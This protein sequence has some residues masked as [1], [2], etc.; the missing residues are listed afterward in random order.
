MLLQWRPKIVITSG[1]RE[2]DNINWMIT[3]SNE[4]T[5][6]LCE[7]IGT[8]SVWSYKPNENISRYDVIPLSGFYRVY[9]NDNVDCYYQAQGR[10]LDNVDDFK[11]TIVHV[12]DIHAHIDEMTESGTRC[13]VNSLLLLLLLL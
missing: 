11:L 13:D 10:T 1:L 7:W 12:N 5:H 9:K 8:L 3:K 4:F 6:A 2:T